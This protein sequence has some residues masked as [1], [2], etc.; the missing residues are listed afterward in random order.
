MHGLFQ[1]QRIVRE[2]SRR[3]CA[4][5]TKRN[6]MYTRELEASRKRTIRRR[7]M[8]VHKIPS[9]GWTRGGVLCALDDLADLA[10]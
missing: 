5:E 9:V 8:V 10:L 7:R 6:V 1:P 3:A 2:R 4:L